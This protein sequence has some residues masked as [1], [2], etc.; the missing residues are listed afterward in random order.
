MQKPFLMQKIVD[1]S[2]FLLLLLSWC[3]II[4]NKKNMNR[5]DENEIY[6]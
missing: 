2:S 5:I 4:S 1:D 6:D 3:D